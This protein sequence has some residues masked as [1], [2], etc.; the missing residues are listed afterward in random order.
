MG[1]IGL[2]L[3]PHDPDVVYATIPARRAGRGFYRSTDRGESWEKRS[4]YVPN[5]PQ[6]YQEI[7]PD[8][9]RPERVY[10]VDVWI[11]MTEDDG[12][13]WNSVN[14]VNSTSTTTRSCS[15][16]RIPTTCWWE[17]TGG[18]TRPGTGGH[19][20][21]RRQPAGDPV[22]PRGHRRRGALLQRVRRH[23]GQQHPGGTV[24]QHDHARHHEIATGSSRSEATATRRASSPA[25]RTSCTRCTST[26]DSSAST[27]DRA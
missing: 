16:P 3:S 7:Y 26:G 25:T 12:V 14:S 18:S 2:A 13:T 20:A 23:P 10:L 24:A 27:G 22:L 21:L 15:T 17:R 8:P 11:Q 4:D 19:V 1:R 5:D 6:Y 9:H